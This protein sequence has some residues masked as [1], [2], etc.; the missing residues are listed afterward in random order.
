MHPN[1]TE[2]LASEENEI[3]LSFSIGRKWPSASQEQGSRW[4]ANWPASRSWVS[5]PQEL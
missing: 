4:E 3:S 2:L 5:Q 1:P